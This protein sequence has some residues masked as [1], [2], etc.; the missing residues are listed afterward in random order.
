MHLF[1]IHFNHLIWNEFNKK[2]NKIAFAALSSYAPKVY[3]SDL[4]FKEKSFIVEGKKC[5]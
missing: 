2:D 1:R 5:E 3:E 4:W